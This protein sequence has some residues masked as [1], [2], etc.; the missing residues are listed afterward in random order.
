M[1]VTKCGVI[2]FVVVAGPPVDSIEFAA[3][4]VLFDTPTKAAALDGVLFVAPITERSV[5]LYGSVWPWVSTAGGPA[6]APG[7]SV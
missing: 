5:L 3:S 4:V 7:V 2:V 1:G 6:T